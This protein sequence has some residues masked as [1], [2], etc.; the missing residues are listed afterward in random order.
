[1]LGLSFKQRFQFPTEQCGLFVG[2][3]LPYLGATPDCLVGDDGLLEVKCPFVANR[4]GMTP[5]DAADLKDF[6]LKS[7]L[8]TSLKLNHDYYYQI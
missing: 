5:Q 1:M 6:C 3:D 4:D 7:A 2:V 8:G